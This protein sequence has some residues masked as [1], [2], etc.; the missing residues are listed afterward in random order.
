MPREVAQMLSSP[1]TI[2]WNVL[3]LHQTG[4]GNALLS[5]GV[6]RVNATDLDNGGLLG[7]V[8]AWLKTKLQLHRSSITSYV[9]S[10]QGEL[11]TT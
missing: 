3:Q 11:S 6:V 1:V 2:S 4:N 7:E 5:N 9:D 10:Q 8:L